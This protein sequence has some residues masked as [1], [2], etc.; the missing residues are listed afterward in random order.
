MSRSVSTL[1]LLLQLPL[2]AATFPYRY[3]PPNVDVRPVQGINE[4]LV[5]GKLHLKLKD[6][7]ELVLKNNTDIALT[8]LE[9]Y[10]AVDAITHADVPTG[11]GAR[12]IA[13][14]V[15]LA[16]NQIFLEVTDSGPGIELDLREARAFS[17][18]VTLRV[19]RP[20]GRAQAAALAGES[21][22]VR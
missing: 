10:N 9:V 12:W 1:L 21:P 15:K 14:S 19:Y 3:Q 17:K 11:V 6:F 13:L 8:R 18:G 7:L 20:G 2:G 16:A 4:R 22:R 5:D